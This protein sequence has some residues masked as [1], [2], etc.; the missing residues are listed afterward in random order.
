MKVISKCR[1]RLRILSSFDSVLSRRAGRG[2]RL[3]ERN[4]DSGD[5]ESKS[6]I[7]H[8]R[9]SP[10][11]LAANLSDRLAISAPGIHDGFLFQAALPD[12]GHC[13][14]DRVAPGVYIFRVCAGVSSTG[15][16]GTA[17]QEWWRKRGGRKREGAYCSEV[18]LL[19]RGFRFPGRVRARHADAGARVRIYAAACGR[20]YVHLIRGTNTRT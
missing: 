1:I 11:R 7:H 8:E 17:G 18:I 13:P 9:V 15:V 3:S 2:M 19:D 10:G 4:G 16:C 14:R 20:V 12:N 5:T 6:I